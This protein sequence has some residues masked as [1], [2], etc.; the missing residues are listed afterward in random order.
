LVL[1]GV[2]V[3]AFVG[4]GF[5][6]LLRFFCFVILCCRGFDVFTI[7]FELGDASL[8]AL[9]QGGGIVLLLFHFFFGEP[10]VG[11]I[12]GGAG[13]FGNAEALALLFIHMFG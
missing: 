12:V 10:A 9:D 4:R 2:Q 13:G 6:V 11:G 7:L 5:R 3:Y 8:V 1:G